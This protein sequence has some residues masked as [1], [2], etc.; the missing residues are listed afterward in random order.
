MLA[1]LVQLLRQPA[2]TLVTLTG[3]PEPGP[4][5]LELLRDP[6]WGPPFAIGVTVAVAGLAG[7]AWV[8]IREWRLQR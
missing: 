3:P 4:L 7:L 6:R 8:G 1:E 5:L 2:G